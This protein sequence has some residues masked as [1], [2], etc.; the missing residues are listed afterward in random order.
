M[1]LKA[2]KQGVV[3]L[4]QITTGPIVATSQPQSPVDL[5]SVSYVDTSIF[6]SDTS[7]LN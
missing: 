3:K 6:N 5:W 7:I 2:K 1:P 4:Y